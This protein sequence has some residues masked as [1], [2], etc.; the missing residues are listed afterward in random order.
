MTAGRNIA[1]ERWQ[2]V[3]WTQRHESKH[4][5]RF[6]EEMV[7]RQQSQV[8]RASLGIDRDIPNT[9]HHYT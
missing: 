2:T 4:D 6:T 9:T 3:L 5:F 1:G 7:Y 8:D